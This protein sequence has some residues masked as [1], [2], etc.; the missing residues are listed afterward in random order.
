MRGLI[1]IFI[2]GMSG[3]LLAHMIEPGFAQ[4]IDPGA[5]SDLERERIQAQDNAT[6]LD[7]ERSVL[8]KDIAKLKSSLNKTASETA[9]IEREG[10]EIET[11]LKSLNALATTYETQII[12]NQA[13][14]VKLIGVLQRIDKT[15]PPALLSGSGDITDYVETNYLIAGVSRSLQA[16][17]DGFKDALLTLGQVEATTLAEKSK[18]KENER[19]LIAKRQKIRGLVGKKS[20][21]EKSIIRES[22]RERSRAEQLASDAVSLRDLISS[23]EKAARDVSPRL[24]PDRQAPPVRSAARPSLKPNKDRRLNAPVVLPPD[25]KRFSDARNS[26]RA[27]VSGQITKKYG[28]SHKGITVRAKSGAQVISPYAGR[29][30]FSGPFKNYENVVI[31][32]VGGSYFIL[33]TGLGDVYAQTGDNIVIGAPLGAMPSKSGAK[34]ELYIEF[35]K[36]GTPIDPKPWLGTAF[37]GLGG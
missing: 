37:A 6:R 16:R 24:K 11:R 19:I 29:I 33:M 28:G 18:L 20:D 13:T 17:S 3:P 21:L 32:N 2:L 26:L 9:K 30:E 36:D 14:F 10:R 4:T 22:K 7:K 25:T 27:P 12:D 23:F 35:R 8:Q 1:S 34:P 31:I 15:P 5:L